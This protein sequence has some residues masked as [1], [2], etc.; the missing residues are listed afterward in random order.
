MSTPR[1]STH[2]LQTPQRAPRAHT[3]SPRGAPRT[4]H[5]PLSLGRSI[6]CPIPLITDLSSLSGLIQ[7]FITNCG[8]ATYGQGM[9]CTPPGSYCTP[10]AR[11]HSA[12]LSRRWRHTRAHRGNELKGVERVLSICP[13][14]PCESATFKFDRPAQASTPPPAARPPAAPLASALA[15]AAR[16]GERGR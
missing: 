5:A 11:R 6:D 16:A 13:C 7:Q 1:Y 2:V 15:A 10:G 14:W 3:R 4:H 9:S 12:A 8:N